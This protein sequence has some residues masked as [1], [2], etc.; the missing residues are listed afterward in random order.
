MS[1]ETVHSFQTKQA[2]DITLITVKNWKQVLYGYIL[3]IT[4]CMYNRTFISV[5]NVLQIM[6]GTNDLD[7]NVYTCK[8]K[9]KLCKRQVTAYKT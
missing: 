8:H 5:Y 3:V 9:F 2:E 6:F 1:N 7:M 4:I